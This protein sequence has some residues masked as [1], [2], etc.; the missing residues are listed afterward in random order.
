MNFVFAEGHL[1]QNESNCEEAD[2]RMRRRST[3]G[4]RNGSF[5]NNPSSFLP[6]QQ[7]PRPLPQRPILCATTG[8]CAQRRPSATA[9]RSRAPPPEAEACRTPPL[10]SRPPP[11]TALLFPPATTTRHLSPKSHRPCLCRVSTPTHISP[12]KSNFVSSH[13]C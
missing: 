1:C 6:A 4:S 3:P 12:K 2:K 5:L 13:L 8:I 9:P 11:S 7:P 10:P